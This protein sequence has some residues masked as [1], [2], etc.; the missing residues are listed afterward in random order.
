MGELTRSTPAPF[1]LGSGDLE[2]DDHS[3]GGT[4]SA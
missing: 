3:L 2:A 4:K 1:R